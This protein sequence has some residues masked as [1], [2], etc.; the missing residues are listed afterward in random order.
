MNKFLRLKIVERFGNQ[1]EFSAAI[2]EHDSVVSRVIR[3]RQMIGEEKQARWAEALGCPV[4][5]LFRD[6]ASNR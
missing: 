2:G 1:T 4:E 3:G 6:G 5:E